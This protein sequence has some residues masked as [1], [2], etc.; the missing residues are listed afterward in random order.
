[1]QNWG[2]SGLT[3]ELWILVSTEGPGI[4]LLRILRADCGAE[5]DSACTKDS[6]QNIHI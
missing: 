6:E 2:Y 5:A 4:N 1:M 3:L